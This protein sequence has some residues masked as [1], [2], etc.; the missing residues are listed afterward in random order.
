ME[1]KKDTERDTDA[2]V[3]KSYYVVWKPFHLIF[4]FVFFFLFKSYYV[5]WKPAKTTTKTMIGKRFKS[6][7]VV[8]KQGE[9]IYDVSI[10]ESLN[11]TM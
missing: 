1:T 11:R 2:K 10:V 9:S 8:W 4:F 6:Y 3:F 5:V 7:Y